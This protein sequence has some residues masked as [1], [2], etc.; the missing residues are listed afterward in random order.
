MRKIHRG[1]NNFRSGCLCSFLGRV[2]INSHH[3][4]LRSGSA[5]SDH[6]QP[7]KQRMMVI[8]MVGVQHEV[9]SLQT[10]RREIRVRILHLRRKHIFIERN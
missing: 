8:G 4:Q 7:L 2:R 6:F 1:L 5:R 3:A 10:Q 9:H